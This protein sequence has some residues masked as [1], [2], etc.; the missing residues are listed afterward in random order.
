M[1]DGNFPTTLK[2]TSVVADLQDIARKEL[3]RRRQRLGQ[4]T[5]EQEEAIESLLMSTVSSISDPILRQLQSKSEVIGN[6]IG[7]MWRDKEADFDGGEQ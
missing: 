2:Y 7:L 6:D 1:P 4:L 5:P 3:T